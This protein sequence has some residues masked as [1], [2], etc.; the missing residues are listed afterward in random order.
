MPGHVGSA[1]DWRGAADVGGMLLNPLHCTGRPLVS[2]RTPAVLGGEPGVVGP[3]FP[4][5]LQR[6]VQAGHSTLTSLL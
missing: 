3:L 6:P 5:A 2:G 4:K 1:H